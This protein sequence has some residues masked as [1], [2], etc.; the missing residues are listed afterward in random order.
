MLARRALRRRSG[1]A[2]A[3]RA[4]TS[5]GRRTRPAANLRPTRALL[6]PRAACTRQAVA[7]CWRRSGGRHLV[8]V[9]ND[10]R[11][12]SVLSGAHAVMPA[13][14]KIAA[15]GATAVARRVSSMRAMGRSSS[16]NHYANAPENS[17][18]RWIRRQNKTLQ[19]S[20][21]YE[22]RSQMPASKP[23]ASAAAPSLQTRRR[24]RA[25]APEILTARKTRRSA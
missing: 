19:V 12:L 21:S 5:P 7:A 25:P 16:D 2:R 24:L 23:F 4:S 10:E 20:A 17:R 11:T 9:R 14:A 18:A 8:R 3:R 22:L 6:C 15:I 1:S 13:A